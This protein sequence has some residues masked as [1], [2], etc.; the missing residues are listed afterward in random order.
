MKKKVLRDEEAYYVSIRS[1]LET[2]RHLLE[3]T[4]KSIMSLK[5]YHKLVLIRKEKLK[6]LEELRQSIKEL[7]FLYNKLSQIL[8]DY[9]KE[10]LNSFKT[11]KHKEESKKESQKDKKES[12]KV[13]SKNYEHSELHKLESALAALEEKLKSLE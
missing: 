3:C 7:I 1:P 5:N 12:K 8:P 13:E 9:D 10:I 11:T 4:K 2:R 6:H